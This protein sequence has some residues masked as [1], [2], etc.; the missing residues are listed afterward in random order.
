MAEERE[1]GDTI[2]NHRTAILE[3][4]N[5]EPHY[6]SLRSNNVR[7]EASIFIFW[8]APELRLDI[9]LD[10]NIWDKVKYWKL[11]EVKKLFF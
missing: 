7:L 11:E 5:C 4:L 1:Y 3:L 2:T 10:I 6:I 8:S 9:E